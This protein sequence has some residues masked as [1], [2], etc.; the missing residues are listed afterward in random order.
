MP[1]AA[2]YLV[3]MLAAA[4]LVFTACKLKSS[5]G[6]KRSR[7]GASSKGSV[8]VGNSQAAATGAKGPAGKKGGKANPTVPPIQAW[9]CGD[10][11]CDL[12]SGEDCIVCPKDCGVCDGC[13]VNLGTGCKGCKCERCV[14]Q[15]LP[16]CCGRK[17]AAWNAKCVEMCKKKCG[18]CGLK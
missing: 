14:C 3:L 11:K 1:R 18:G 16:K 17:N 5:T 8:G 15:H 9:N 2:K 4:S 12:P 10:G 7:P 13:K 6:S